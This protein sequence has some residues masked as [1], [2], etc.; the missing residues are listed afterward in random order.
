MCRLIIYQAHRTFIRHSS[1][2][3]LRI[4]FIIL[5]HHSILLISHNRGNSTIIMHA[6]IR[7]IDR[8]QAAPPQI[9]W[10]I[11]HRAG[12]FSSWSRLSF[13]SAAASAWL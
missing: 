11:Q 3:T 2:H 8:T 6:R 10:L 5:I 13:S 1:I 12:F 7:S 9:S 4:R